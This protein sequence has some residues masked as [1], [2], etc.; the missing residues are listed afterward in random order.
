MKSIEKTI[1]ADYKGVN[2]DDI[3]M[4]YNIF[5]DRIDNL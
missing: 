2:L 3:L 5:E 4:V 1:D